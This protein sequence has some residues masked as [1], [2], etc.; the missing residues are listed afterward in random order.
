MSPENASWAA[1][2]P[3]ETVSD[4]L[5]RLAISYTIIENRSRAAELEK[6]A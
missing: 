6:T 3:D 4:W 5:L 1:R 2:E